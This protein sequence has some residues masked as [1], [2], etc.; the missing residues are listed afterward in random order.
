LADCRLSD[1][2]TDPDATPMRL[3][4]GGIHLGYHVHYVVD[5]GKRRIIL[6][7]LV[8]PGEVMDNQPMLDLRLPCLISLARA[9][10][11]GDRRYHLRNDREYQSH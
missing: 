7:V 1:Q 10:K 2:S 4:G 9:A 6:A 5:G 3:K 11:A 8:T